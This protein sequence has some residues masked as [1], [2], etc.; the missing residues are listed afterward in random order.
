MNEDFLNKRLE[1]R[2]TDQSLRRL[3]TAESGV[4]FCSNDYLGIATGNLLKFSYT[5]AGERFH[6][7]TGSRLISGNYEMAEEAEREISAFHGAESGLLFNSGYDA[8]LGLLSC[9]PQRGDTVLYDALSHAS[10]RDGI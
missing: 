8:N 3:I 10:I 7:S 4:D 2:K 1:L 5:D 6:G 9:V